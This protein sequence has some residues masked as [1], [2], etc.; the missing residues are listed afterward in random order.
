M[1][2]WEGVGAHSMFKRVECLGGVVEGGRG[3]ERGWRK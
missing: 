2:L 3:D 1:R